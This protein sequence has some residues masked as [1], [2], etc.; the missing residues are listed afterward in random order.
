MNIF[1]L[2]NF[3][4]LYNIHWKKKRSCAKQYQTNTWKFTIKILKE[5]TNSQIKIHRYYII[6]ILYWYNKIINNNNY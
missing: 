6:I 3:I 5:K 1:I 4:K 2:S